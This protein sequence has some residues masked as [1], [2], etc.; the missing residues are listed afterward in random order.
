MLY[1][2]CSNAVFFIPVVD[3]PLAKILFE[4]HWEHQLKRYIRPGSCSFS[5]A[6]RGCLTLYHCAISPPFASSLLPLACCWKQPLLLASLDELAL[7]KGE[8]WSVQCHLSSKMLTRLNRRRD[9]L[10]QVLEN[11][12]WPWKTG[13]VWCIMIKLEYM[14]MKISLY[15]TFH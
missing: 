1:F 9:L 5:F 12:G 8:W 13:S 3:I 4:T 7:I 6:R 14:M 2:L 11:K 15:A 10:L